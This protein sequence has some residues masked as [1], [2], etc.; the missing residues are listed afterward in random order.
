MQLLSESVAPSVLLRG[1]P[2]YCLEVAVEGALGI[3]A[4]GKI[5]AC[6]AYI[7]TLEMLA[8][9]FDSVFVKKSFE[10]NAEILV[11]QA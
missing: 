9:N 7:L 5:H 4:R 6:D 1:H 10:R 11:Y 2:H 8:S 3:K